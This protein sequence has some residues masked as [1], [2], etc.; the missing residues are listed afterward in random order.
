MLKPWIKRTLLT[1]ATATF[2][3]GLAAC[4]G[5]HHRYGGMS[6]DRIVAMRG[7]VVERI[8]SKLALDANQKTKLDVVAN[9]LLAQRQALRGSSTGSDHHAEFKAIVAN[10]TFDRAAARR[11][12]DQKV[13]SVQTQAPKVLDAMADFYDSLSVQQQAQVRERMDKHGR[14]RW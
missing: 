10:K 11:L 14:S 13:G 3:L 2:V 1:A 6:E 9:E 4:G 12:L 7:K 8:S 5:N